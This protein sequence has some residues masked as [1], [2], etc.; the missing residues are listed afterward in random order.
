MRSRLLALPIAALFLAA[1]SQ[2]LATPTPDTTLGA[3]GAAP[4]TYIMD[5]ESA[6]E[7]KVLWDVKVGRGVKYEGEGKA[8][9]EKI[10]VDGYNIVKGK[11]VG[12]NSAVVFNPGSSFTKILGV[13]PSNENQ[14]G[15]QLEIKPSQAFGG[16]SLGKN[17]LVTLKRITI[18]NVQTDG[19]N[20][21]LYGNG[22]F[23]KRISLAKTFV[24]TLELNEPG[25][26][27]IQLNVKNFFAVDNVVF[28]VPDK[29]ADFVGKEIVGNWEGS[30][31]QAG[32]GS[33]SINLTVTKDP[34]ADQVSA[35]V[36][37]PSLACGGNWTFKSAEVSKYTFTEQITSGTN[38]CIVSS[39]V[40]VT[41]NQDGSLTYDWQYYG[42]S[43]TGT[44]HRIKD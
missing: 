16:P 5:F 14:Q 6:P 39:D 3:S 35:T 33:Y 17:G 24:Q 38:N 12:G 11:K 20:I 23:L 13:L 18:Y 37:Y 29:E 10:R 22:G 2:N 27:F 30:A 8:L 32:F 43:A 42:A 25:V 15:G 44:L 36:S 40:S 21:V 7:L 41:Y 1:C 34:S 9:T 19:A 31:Y 26:G 4:D 28:E